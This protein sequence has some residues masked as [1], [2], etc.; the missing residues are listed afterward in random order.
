MTLTGKGSPQQGEILL[1]ARHTP[2][3]GSPDSTVTRGT[4]GTEKDR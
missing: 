1:A 3:N 4:I 2:G